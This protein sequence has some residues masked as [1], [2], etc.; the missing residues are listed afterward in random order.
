MIPDR[1]SPLNLFNVFMIFLKYGFY[2]PCKYCI[3]KPYNYCLT[4]QNYCKRS[5]KH[6]EDHI[7]QEKYNDLNEKHKQL[8]IVLISL[9]EMIHEN[10]ENINDKFG[11]LLRSVNFII[12]NKLSDIDSNLSD[13]D[14]KLSI[15][16]NKELNNKIKKT[17]N[18]CY[19]GRNIS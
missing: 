5:D 14:S 7:V 4:I 13:I 17:R 3:A 11:D 15:L 6:D 1:Y 16:E 18:T 8:E 9:I 10:N 2:E 12:E 19:R